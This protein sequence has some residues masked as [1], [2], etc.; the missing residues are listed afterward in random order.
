MM[1]FH[2][3]FSGIFSKIIWLIIEIWKYFHIHRCPYVPDKEDTR[4]DPSAQVFAVS[5][6]CGVEVYNLRKVG[7]LFSKQNSSVFNAHTI[8]I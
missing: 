8:S 5:R 2:H 4:E 1:S 7:E 3:E 6:G